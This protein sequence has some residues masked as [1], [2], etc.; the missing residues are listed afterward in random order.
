MNKSV[1]RQ[2]WSRRS[3]RR[4]PRVSPF[5]LASTGRACEACSAMRRVTFADS[6]VAQFISQLCLPVTIQVESNPSI[7]AEFLV[8]WTPL[9]VLADCTGRGHFRIEGWLPPIDF[10]GRLSIGV[11]RYWLNSGQLGLA[12]HRFREVARRHAGSETAAEC[13]TGLASRCIGSTMIGRYCWRHGM[14]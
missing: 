8:A 12:V 13:S 1:G 11:G 14:N 3:T 6:R 9:C 2:A 5:S 10:L 7:A 4:F